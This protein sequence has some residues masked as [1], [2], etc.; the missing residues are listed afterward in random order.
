M[1]YDRYP[2]LLI[3]EKRR[4]LEDK[5]ARGVRL[6]FTHDLEC[7]VASPVRDG[8]RFAVTAEAASL[9]GEQR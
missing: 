1:G 3:D 5:I 2:E 7:A 8:E 9:E 6:F 4:F